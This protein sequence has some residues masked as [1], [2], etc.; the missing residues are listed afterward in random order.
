MNANAERINTKIEVD[1]IVAS[2]FKR[3]KATVL[4]MINDKTMI[5]RWEATGEEAEVLRVAFILA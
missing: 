5:V 4:K 2:A 3:N 1:S